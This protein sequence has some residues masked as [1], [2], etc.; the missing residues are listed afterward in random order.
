MARKPSTKT[1]TEESTVTTETEAPVEATETTETETAEVE[2]DLTAFEAAA[3][4]AVKGSDESTGDVPTSLIDPVVQAYRALPGVKAKNAAKRAIDEAMTSAMDDMDIRVAKA[5]LLLSQNLTAGSTKSSAPKAPVDPTEAFVERVAGLRLALELASSNVPEGVSDEWQGKAEEKV[6]AADEQSRAF[7]AWSTDEA[8]DKGDAPEVDQ[9]V[10]AAVK[11]A[12]GKSAKVG[13]ARAVG[14]TST[15]QGERR[16][17]RKHIEEV[18]EG[19]DSGTFL[20]VSE[21]RKG[22]SEEYGDDA[23]S[24]G[25]VT[26][27]LKSANFAVEGVTPG[28]NDA[29][30]LGA[31]KA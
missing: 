30:K 19:V 25:A 18:F 26:Q 28:T 6:A 2:F 12:L 22:K 17:V 3:Q 10:S 5:N 24:A 9:F 15:F 31:H 4:A 20:T 21:I 14:G 7:Y 29:G 16:N 8:E 27:A 13:R 23:P 1:T 11:L